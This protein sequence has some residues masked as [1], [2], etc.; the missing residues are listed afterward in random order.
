M[1][2]F[3]LDYQN[4]P[5]QCVYAKGGLKFR[6]DE[7]ALRH[8]F[9]PILPYVSLNDLIGESVFWSMLPSTV[10]IW[11]FPFLL[12]SQGILFAIIATLVLYLVAE[13]GHMAFYI[14]PLNYVVFILGNQFLSL[15]VYII[16]AVILILSGSIVGAII[17]GVWF[18]FFALGLSQIIFLF[19]IIPFLTKL[20]SLPPSDQVLKNVGWHYARKFGIDP[21]KWKMYDQETGN[22]G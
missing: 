19:P 5:G 10:A 21:T 14:K 15:V 4:M 13:I 20:F 17:L 2:L 8:Y 9:A 16:W 3:S 22:G 1:G 12:H 7:D 6:A 18:L 11:T